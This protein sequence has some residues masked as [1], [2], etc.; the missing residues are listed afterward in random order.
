MEVVTTGAI[1]TV[2]NLKLEEVTPSLPV[3][4]WEGVDTV[5]GEITPT[6]NAFCCGFTAFLSQCFSPGTDEF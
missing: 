1:G 5:S 4:S 3:A 2:L 6:R